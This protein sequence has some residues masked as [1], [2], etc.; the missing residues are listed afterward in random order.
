MTAKQLKIALA[1][2]QEVDRDLSRYDDGALEGCGLP[3]F[4][5]VEAS[6]GAVARLLR[7]QCL[8]LNG[9]WDWREYNENMRPILLSKRVSV[10]DLTVGE[11]RELLIE[12]CGKV[13][14]GDL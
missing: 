1:M 11:S 7:W 8:M 14:G 6:L 13:L 12:V 3:D 2:A 9:E 5:P 10:A 4:E